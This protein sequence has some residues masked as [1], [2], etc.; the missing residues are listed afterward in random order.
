M[1]IYAYIYI[2]IYICIHLFIYRYTYI[3]IYIYVYKIKSICYLFCIYSC[4]IYVGISSIW[5]V[6]LATAC[7]TK[8]SSHTMNDTCIQLHTMQVV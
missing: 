2:H 5:Y 7:M 4:F 6:L 1:N 8:Q 3:Y